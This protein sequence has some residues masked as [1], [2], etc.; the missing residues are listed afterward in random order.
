[1]KD[2]NKQETERINKL[3]E[4]FRNA[5]AQNVIA[6]NNLKISELMQTL[7]TIRFTLSNNQ[8]ATKKLG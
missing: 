5:S 4:A 7:Q 6:N 8:R 3:E 1:M 2:I